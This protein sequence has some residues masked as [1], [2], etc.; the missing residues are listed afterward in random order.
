MIGLNMSRLTAANICLVYCDAVRSGL[1]G[2][3][4]AQEPTASTPCAGDAGASFDLDHAV[5]VLVDAAMF[6][7]EA[8][9]RER[10]GPDG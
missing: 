4:L 6:R 5:G 2:A 7:R 1:G 9:R 8:A 3:W 10:D